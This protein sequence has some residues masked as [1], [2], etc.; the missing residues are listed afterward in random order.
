MQIRNSVHHIHIKCHDPKTAADWYGDVFGF[1]VVADSVRPTGDRLIRCALEGNQPPFL[2]ISNPAR[3]ELLP[4][5]RYESSLGL[6][7]FA[8]TTDNLETLVERA[9]AH[10]AEL[11]DKPATLQD[12]TLIAFIKTP[13]NLRI[14]LMQLPQ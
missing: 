4:E 3:G 8:I 11:L 13:Q 9:R 12:G 14:E 6:E 1:E 7:H 10:G 5:G 2:I